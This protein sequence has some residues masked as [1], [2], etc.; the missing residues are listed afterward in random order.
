M[1]L[2]NIRCGATLDKAGSVTFRTENPPPGWGTCSP[3]TNVR[4]FQHHQFGDGPGHLRHG[5]PEPRSAGHAVAA[6]EKF[7]HHPEGASPP[8]DVVF[9]DQDEVVQLRTLSIARP[10]P[11]RE[12]RGEVTASPASPPF[13][14][15]LL[16]VPPPALPP[17]GPIPGCMPVRFGVADFGKVYICA[18]R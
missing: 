16:P 4:W 9:Q 18:A 2:H 14:D 17:P 6:W 1:G 11:A 5:G 3:I 7:H 10:F 8:R 15:Q 12:Q 13:G